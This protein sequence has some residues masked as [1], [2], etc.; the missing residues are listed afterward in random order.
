[1][2]QEHDDSTI[3]H[4]MACSVEGCDFKIEVHA[5]DDEEAIKKVMEAGK[6]HLGEAHPDAKEVSSEGMETATRAS[7]TKH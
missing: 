3:T 5:D 7:I 1:M 6:E 4:S 2:D